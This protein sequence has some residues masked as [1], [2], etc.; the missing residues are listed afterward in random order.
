MKRTLVVLTVLMATS[1][2]WA[3][4]IGFIEDFSLSENRPSALKQLIPGTEQ[5]YYY[6]CLHYQ[7]TG[8]EK[9][10][11]EMLALWIKRR[12]TR[13]RTPLMREIENRQSLLNYQNDQQATLKYL[14]ERLNLRFDHQRERLG[15]KTRLP[16]SLDSNLISRDTLTRRALGRH[17]GTVNGFENSALEWLIARDIGADRR[18]HLL[19]RLTRPDVPNL[20]K[21]I[22]ADLNHKYS[23]GFGSMNIHR[24]LLLSQLDKCLELK[25][26]LLNNTRFVNTYHPA[27]PRRWP[28]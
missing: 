6:H 23:G 24:A 2:C 16:T 11:N 25:G 3:G 18:R 7:N 13:S 4:Q 19:K 10:L 8:Q 9:K 26:D 5:Y 22:V 1:A 12:G 17:R 28:R 21:I 14:R 27:Q 20:P 15:R